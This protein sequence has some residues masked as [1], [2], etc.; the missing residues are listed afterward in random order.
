[1]YRI[2]FHG[3][4]G[5]GM[6]TAGR[7]LGSAFFAEGFEVQDAPL[8]G[9]ERRGAPVLA[10]VRAARRPIHERGVIREPDLVIVADDTLLQVPAA[11]VL[12]G[13]TPHAVLLIQGYETPDT[14]RT[15]LHCA[16]PV[17]IL[18][19]PGNVEDRAEW[20]YGGA[21]CA[22]A[23]ACL[24][25]LQCASLEQAIRGE[26]AEADAAV[27]EH[28]LNEALG[29]YAALA[30]HTGLV[31]EGPVRA[32]DAYAPPAWIDLPL[33]D[34]D[35]AAPDIHG[36]ATSLQVKTGLWRTLRP[37]IDDH[38]CR[39]CLDCYTLCP[40]GAITVEDGKPRIDYE[41]CKGCLICVVQCPFH[42][43][44]AMPEHAA[45]AEAAP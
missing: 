38:Y 7:I 40:D 3:R 45:V 36:E 10:H 43:L 18:P 5:Q 21:A 32:M 26:L 17:L 33:D 15:R 8:Y 14:L 23:A 24:V 6:K 12:N 2:R 11:G 39:R 42:A 22:G 4:G 16:C 34:T 28:D 1:M 31:K 29:A 25:G 35:A 27:I 41:H 20:P 44:S 30:D 9:A 19:A 37:V 13:I